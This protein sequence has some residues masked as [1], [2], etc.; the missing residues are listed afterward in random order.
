MENHC[1]QLQVLDLVSFFRLTSN[2]DIQELFVINLIKGVLK[3]F[4]I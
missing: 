1:D 4:L 2:S 3:T